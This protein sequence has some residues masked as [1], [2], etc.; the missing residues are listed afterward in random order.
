VSMVSDGVNVG[1]V[2]K[3]TT[4]EKV[5]F[6]IAREK[7]A[8]LTS[9]GTTLQ[10]LVQQYLN[11][12]N[13]ELFPI[14]SQIAKNYEEYIPHHLKVFFRTEEYMASGTVVSAGLAAMGTN[15]DPDAPNFAT[16]TELENYEHSISGPPFS[17][18]MVHDVLEER[19]KRG[20]QRGGAGDLALKNYF[21]NF[22]PNQAAPTGTP[23]KFYD[24]GNFQAL[25]NGTQAGVVGE[26]WIEYGFTLIRRLQ[27]PGAPLGG[28]AHFTG[29]APTTA[30]NFAGAVLQPGNTLGGITLGTNTVNFPANQPG[31][32]LYVMSVTGSTSATALGD[33]N[34][35]A[36]T[37]LKYWTNGGVVDD[38]SY[39]QSAAGGASIPTIIVGTIA[40]GNAGAA[41]ALPPSTLV[42]GNAMDLWIIALPSTVLTVDEKEQI[43][44]DDLKARVVAQDARMA[45]LEAVLLSLSANEEERKVSD[46]PVLVPTISSV[47]RSFHF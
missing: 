41:A 5:T 45:R 10:T 26:L 42:G 24:I 4:A 32:Y 13:S 30:N 23:S 40:V 14:F 1:S 8:D 9:S 20:N 31:N 36:V 2:W 17:G 43:E 27:Q 15:F 33:L 38:V 21:V 6:P 35:A 16:M 12:G 7:F 47:R 44:I 11:P 19:R 22:S 34:G 39:L 25:V 29:V 37:Q 3:N 18:I 46:S 28:V